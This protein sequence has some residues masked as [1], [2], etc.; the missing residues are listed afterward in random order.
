M[1]Y[2]V[3]FVGG[4]PAGYV[5]AIRAANL[6]LKVA[7]VEKEKVGGT[8]LHRGCIPTKTLISNSDVVRQIKLAK[9]Y[10][11]S[12]DR[13]S[14]DYQKMKERKDSVIG[15][16]CKG[17][18]GLLKS[19]GVDLFE[20]VASF[21]SVHQ[22]KVKSKDQI[23]LVEFEQAV[24]ATGSTSMN[25][26]AAI[27]DGRKIHDSTS[28][29]E[30]TALPRSLV[31]LGG[32][33]IGCEFASLFSE[34]GV[35]VTIVEF[36]PDI[37]S[38]MGKSISQFL[39]KSFQK[40]GVEIR[41]GVKLLKAEVAGNQVRSSLS[42]GAAIESEM[43]LVA[44]GRAPYTEGLNLSAI[45]LGLN[46]RGFIEVNHRMETEVKGIYAVGDVT[47]IAMLAHV[48][49]HQ[50]IVAAERI[51]G[52][53][54]HIDYDSVP[55]VMF[56]HPEIATVGLSHEKAR[57]RGLDVRSDTFPFSAL[58]KA[59][60]SLETEGFAEVVTEKKSGRIVGAFMVGFEA[61][62]MIAAM[63]LAIQNELTLE[64]ITE[65]IFAHPTL[66]ESWM[67]VALIAQDR[68]IHFPPVKKK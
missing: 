52:L 40:R 25:I 29:L 13:F 32:G 26:P 10:G 64:S 63:T 50:A 43:L 48:A 31:V 23:H 5:G 66:S 38:N 19:H 24:I 3:C 17:V 45:G 27:V 20:G 21:E 28:I 65:T 61:G 54:S 41:T 53:N 68:P 30:L 18:L 15:N 55:A 51:A 36:L 67:E 56:T 16:L 39:T 42:D 11:I 49:S 59:Q 47:G 1:R 2:D 35:S 22:V 12:V 60:A 57:E 34:L 6:G 46:H 62:N 14:I 37:V 33:Y 9:E 58:G 8:C 7:L 4:G 44:V